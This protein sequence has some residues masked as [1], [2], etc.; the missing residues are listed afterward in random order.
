MSNSKSAKREE[1][2]AILTQALAPKF[3]E[4]SDESHMHHRGE[5][6]HFNVTIVS[7]QFLGLNRVK[8]SQ[9][10]YALLDTFFKNGLHALTQTCL[11]PEEW[12]AGARGT[13]S[14]SC[15]SKKTKN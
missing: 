1:I 4:V 5:N 15:V 14:P 12:A 9:K 7:E 2:V 8:R 3:L 6:S 10:V 13:D 11:T